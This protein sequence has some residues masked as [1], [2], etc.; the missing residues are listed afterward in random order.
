MVAYRW[1]ALAPV[2]TPDFRFAIVNAGGDVIALAESRAAANLFI[3]DCFQE[4]VQALLEEVALGGKLDRM[5]I[6]S[7]QAIP[8]RA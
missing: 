2:Q 5:C 8:D 1:D 6:L 4:Y 3:C 7:Q